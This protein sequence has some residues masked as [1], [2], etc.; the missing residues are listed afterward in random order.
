MRPWTRRTRHDRQHI[1]GKQ[2]PGTAYPHSANRR[3]AR[4]VVQT[5]FFSRRRP[6]IVQADIPAG[7]VGEWHCGAERDPG[8]RATAGL[9]PLEGGCGVSTVRVT[10]RATTQPCVY[11]TGSGETPADLIL[12]E[13]E[14]RTLRPSSGHI[15][16]WKRA[17][18]RV[19][20]YMPWTLCGKKAPA[21]CAMQPDFYCP[22]IR[23]QRPTLPVRMAADRDLPKVSS[24]CT[25]VVIAR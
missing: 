25:T 17:S 3:R 23:G 19:P 21:R 8:M 11:W 10:P 1:S 12:T 16:F 18:V 4:E 9:P 15:H 20:K 14:I 24:S 2:L 22:I 5:I 13:S 6:A 7:T